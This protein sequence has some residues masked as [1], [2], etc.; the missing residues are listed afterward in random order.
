MKKLRE[1]GMRHRPLNPAAIL[2][3]LTA[4]AARHNVMVLLLIVCCGLAVIGG[5]VVRDLQAATFATRAVYARSVNGLQQIGEMQYDA[6]ETRRATL[7]ALTTNDS[8]LQVEYADQSRNAD[9]RV[10]DAIVEY[11]S[12]VI[13]PEEISIAKRLSH[14][15]EGYLAIRDEVLASI[16]EGS[17]R[18]AVNLDLSRGVPA[19]DRVRHDLDQVKLL[20]RQD[21]ARR[22]AELAA[23]SRRS[24]SRL[25]GIL[26]FTFLLS[27]AAVWAIQRSHMLGTIQ[28]AKLQMEFVA[29]VSH[30]LRTPLAVPCL[31]QTILPTG[32]WRV[33][34]R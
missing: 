14:D 18:E 17:T 19:F 26:S 30:E 27:G 33:R 11:R 16:L 5:S 3:D 31:R 13:Q 1:F 9:K 10:S 21:A 23:S 25:I 6:Q 20:Y 28:L 34:R 29:S 12:Q 8:N 32:W 24:V 4:G 15:W 7:Y 22:Q 2:D